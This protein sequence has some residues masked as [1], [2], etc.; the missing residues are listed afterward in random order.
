MSVRCTGE[1]LLILGVGSLILLCES[2]IAASYVETLKE[3]LLLAL[4]LIHTGKKIG[5]PYFQH[6]NARPHSAK[7]TQNFLMEHA[8]W[9]LD[10]PAQSPD[11]NLIENVWREVKR[12]VNLI[13]RCYRHR[14]I[15]HQNF[16]TGWLTV[17]PV[18]LQHVLRLLKG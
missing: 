7:L 8:I 1:A 11:L 14:K 10:W 2:V 5:R 13:F 3:H 6:D 15:Y 18:M 16:A 17:C 12:M 4:E 9:V